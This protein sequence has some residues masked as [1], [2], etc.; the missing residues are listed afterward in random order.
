MYKADCLCYDKVIDEI[1]VVKEIAPDH[2]AQFVKYMK[3][4]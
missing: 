4:S 1:K 3:A 2:K